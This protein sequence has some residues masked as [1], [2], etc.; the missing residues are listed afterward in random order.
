MIASLGDDI[1]L[2]R[3]SCLL[4][5]PMVLLR[6]RVRS[7]GLSD[8]RS[9]WSWLMGWDDKHSRSPRCDPFCPAPRIESRSSGSSAQPRTIENNFK[10]YQRLQT[11][12]ILRMRVV[13]EPAEALDPRR[14][15]KGLQVWGRKLIIYGLKLYRRAPL[16][17]ALPDYLRWWQMAPIIMLIAYY[18]RFE[19]IS[20]NPQFDRSSV[21]CLY[22]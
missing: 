11:W 22:Q 4:E 10:R 7:H 16:Y 18:T 21:Y 15:P 17:I 5:K 9:N 19:F 14:W 13:L 6:R 3:W 12:Q 8:L 1:N 2:N 20:F